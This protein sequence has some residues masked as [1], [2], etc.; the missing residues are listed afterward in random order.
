[1]DI[2]YRIPDPPT[3]YELVQYAL[4]SIEYAM[5]DLQMS[6]WGDMTSE[7]NRV[8]CDALTAL[9]SYHPELDS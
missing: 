2:T 9:R 7:A 3:P 4:A 5:S 1:M 6:P 8:L